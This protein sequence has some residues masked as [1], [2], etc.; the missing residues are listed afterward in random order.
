MRGKLPSLTRGHCPQGRGGLRLPA[1]RSSLPSHPSP[2][3]PILRLILRHLWCR[4]LLWYI[5]SLCAMVQEEDPVKRVS[6]GFQGHVPAGRFQLAFPYRN[7]MPPH[8]CQ[9]LL[10]PLVPLLVAY[11]LCMPVLGSRLRHH[12]QPA[13]LM[14]MPEA[15][16]HK[17]A[18]PV[19]PQHYVRFPRQSRMVK[20]ISKATTPQEFPHQHFRLRIL[21][22]YRSHAP[23]PLFRSQFVHSAIGVGGGF[24]IWFA[25]QF[26]LVLFVPQPLHGLI[27]VAL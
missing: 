1:H 5:I 16:V 20:P 14:P 8:A 22:L 19:F 11:Y 9:F 4:F 7:A 13:P 2:F 6:Q 15:P 21:S 24:L 17:D 12:E 26:V 23:V 27:K 25:F 10:H 18:R 3:I